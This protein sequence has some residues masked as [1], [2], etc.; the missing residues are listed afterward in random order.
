[1]PSKTAAKAKASPK[2][3]AA[4]KA[5]RGPSPYIVFCTEQRSKIKAANP[6]ATFGELGKLLGA[7]WGKMSDAQK[8]VKLYFSLLSPS[9][10]LNL[11]SCHS[12]MS[13]RPRRRRLS[14]KLPIPF[15]LIMM[16]LALHSFINWKVLAIVSLKT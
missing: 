11:T 13:K 5:K 16:D 6:S 8:K 1:M 7:A 10:Y 9:I 3:A 15:R 4:P 14:S 2:K 12:L